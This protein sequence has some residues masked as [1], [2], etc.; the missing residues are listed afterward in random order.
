M[1]AHRELPTSGRH[2]FGVGF[3][4][5][6]TTLLASLLVVLWGLGRAV[7]HP[8]A[9]DFLTRWFLGLWD[10]L[11]LDRTRVAFS[12][13]LVAFA[14]TGVLYAHL[15]V[16]TFGPVFYRVEALATRPWLCGLLFAPVPW[17]VTLF[18]TLP[19]VGAG[20]LGSALASGGF[21]W[22]ALLAHLLHGLL[23]GVWF[24][25]TARSG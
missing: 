12:W 22:L 4:A 7:M 11:V 17:L 1:I 25:A 21:A 23:L 9:T 19:L 24:D 10:N 6:A 15:Y 2:V 18:V 8:E 5:T 20:F 3:A 13:S 14:L 16:R